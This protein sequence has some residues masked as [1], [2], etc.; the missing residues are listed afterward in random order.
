[1]Q[2]SF[3]PASTNQQ[4]ESL[5]DPDSPNIIIKIIVQGPCLLYWSNSQGPVAF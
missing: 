4:L 5:K 3:Y 1:M 2:T